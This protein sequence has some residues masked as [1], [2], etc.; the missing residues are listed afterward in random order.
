MKKRQLFALWLSLPL[1]IVTGAVQAQTAPYEM[2]FGYRRV[3]IDGNEQMYR[4]QINERSGFLLHSLTLNTSDFEGKT[5]LFDRF[6]VDAS[7]LGAGPAG[8][9][10][11][12]ANKA[13]VYRFTLGYRHADVY[14]AV[15]AFANPLLSGGVIPGQHTWNR[16]R[17]MIDFDLELMPGRAITPFIGYSSN[18]M[19]GP[20][21][22]TYHQ[23]GEEFLISQNLND[24]ERE[25]RVGTGFTFGKL[26]YGSV[27]EGLRKSRSRENYALIGPGTGNSTTPVLGKDP[28]ATA[29]TR[30]DAGEVRTPFTNF[31]ATAQVSD[32]VRVT[33]NYA[34]LSADG[35]GNESESLAGSFNSFA[36]S[37]FFTGL[38]ETAAQSARNKTWR[39]GGRAEMSVVAGLEAFVSYQQ[40][41]RDLSGT[42]LI[43]TLYSGTTNF[44]GLD[45][46]NVQTVLNAESGMTRKDDVASV[47]VAAHPAGPFSLRAEYRH[48]RQNVEVAPDLSEIV[49]PGNQGGD[50]KR[51]IATFDINGSMSRAGFTLGAAW[52]RDTAD[53]VIL[54][55]DFERRTRTRVRGSYAAPKW[56]K[57][58]AVAENLEQSNPQAGIQMDGK[59]RQYSADVEVAPVKTVALR[60]SVSQFKADNSMVY[61]RPENF[62]TDL[63]VY[64][65]KGKARE[66]GVMLNV[67]PFSVDASVSKFTNRGDNPF[68]VNR[69]RVR[70][71]LDIPK[72]RA[73][74]VV[75][76]AKDKYHELNALF[77]DFDSTRFGIFLRLHP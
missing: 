66:G 6:R 70:V 5:S 44:A 1:V 52:R 30:N 61:R 65:E 47:G 18:D 28:S 15:P 7:D 2:E 53:D 63:S 23:G 75:E 50:Y 77:G 25:Y 35:S 51:N 42:A 31:Y 22:T 60:G 72:T 56:V 26:V 67:A 74:V 45:P 9:L 73:G 19:T 68:D 32:Q 38:T 17:N 4:S 49:V 76:Y 57:L 64:A 40:D 20:G 3:K 39:G 16:T 46:Q 33:G 11:I 13:D 36:I 21:T 71:G 59:V 27:T 14:S 54:R 24:R 8:S 10:R 34:R 41:H 55:T 69:A 48:T 12:E 43:N 29:I 58:G 62:T 37:R